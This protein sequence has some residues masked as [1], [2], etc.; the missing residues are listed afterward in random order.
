[1]DVLNNDALMKKLNESTIRIHTVEIQ[2]TCEVHQVLKKFSLL[3]FLEVLRIRENSL[4]FKD[5]SYLRSFLKNASNQYELDLCHTKFKERS[6]LAFICAL[7]HCKNLTSLILTDN[8]LTEEEINGLITVFE[9]VKNLK[10]LKLSKCILTETQANAILHK[11]E[12]AKNI[13][14]LDLSHNGI[15]GNDIIVG[16]CQLQFLEELNLSHNRV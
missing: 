8:S 11:H 9:S 3:S 16:I 12:Q 5:V 14:T 2:S 7:H 10:T 6:F 13:V 15:Q 1:M 4:K